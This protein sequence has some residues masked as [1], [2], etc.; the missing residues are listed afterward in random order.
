MISK[1]FRQ[2]KLTDNIFFMIYILYNRHD[3]IIYLDNHQQV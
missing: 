2:D 3:N 1:L